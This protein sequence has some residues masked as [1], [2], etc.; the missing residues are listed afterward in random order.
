MNLPSGEICP[1]A[2]SG[3]PQNSSRSISGGW[4]VDLF[5]ACCASAGIV[6]AT[7]AS[8]IEQ[9]IRRN[10]SCNFMMLPEGNQPRRNEEHEERTEKTFVFFVSSW[11]ISLTAP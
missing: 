8:R 2:I 11:L 9:T 1:P 6:S 4:P 3:L 10:R 5:E 7:A